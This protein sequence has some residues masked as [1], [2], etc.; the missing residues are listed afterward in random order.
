[1]MIS[2]EVADASQAAEARRVA[3]ALAK[4]QG[5]SPEE[6]GRVSI[7]A[8]ELATNLVKH[9]GRGEIL[10]GQYND[11][12][13]TGIEC[14]SLDRGP[15][16]KDVQGSLRDG[17]STA[18]SSGQGLG[19]IR[20]QSHFFDVYS[21]LGIGTVVLARLKVGR[22]PLEMENSPPWGA[23]CIP[24]AGEAACGDAWHAV[25]SE[26]GETVMVADGLGHGSL[27][28][29]ASLAAIRIFQKYSALPLAE[30]MERTHDGLRST[31]G[32]AV[33]IARIDRSV[34]AVHF[35]GVGN[36]AGSVISLS[37]MKK[38][39]SHNGTVGHVTRKIQVFSYPYE[40]KGLVILHSD[41][42]GTSWALDR[43]PGLTHRHPSLLS[44][45]L[46]RDF[47]RARDDATVV[48]VGGLAQ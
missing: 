9:A 28:A 46:L 7:V 31:R 39:I 3:A 44:A 15:G 11:P 22:L 4:E 25:Q 20:R 12:G 30:I 6:A 40:G 48:A 32:A 23:V 13:G 17:F 38:M 1:M 47:T 10:I 5:F 27:A 45:V 24:K 19:A 36:I 43:Y 33:G 29:E 8:S 34:K 2:V 26:H 18:G 37:G 21:Q 14:I 35:V 41:G 16:I 42:V